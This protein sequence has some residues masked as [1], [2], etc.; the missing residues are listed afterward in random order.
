MNLDD[1]KTIKVKIQGNYRKLM[2]ERSMRSKENTKEAVVIAI[3]IF[4]FIILNVFEW[5]IYK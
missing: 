2:Q 5:P 3:L 1:K 4:L